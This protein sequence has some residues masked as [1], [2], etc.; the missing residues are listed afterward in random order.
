MTSGEKY[1]LIS[2]F[3]FYMEVYMRKKFCVSDYATDDL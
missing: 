2:L 1:W 3:L